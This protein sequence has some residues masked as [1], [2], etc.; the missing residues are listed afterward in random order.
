MESKGEIVIYQALD[1]QSTI[2][3]KLENES[4]WLNLL[5]IST[6]FEK[7]KSV[8]SRHLKNIYREG[9]LD[10]RATVAKNATVQKEGG[11]EVTREIEYFNLDAILSVGYRVNSIRGTQFRIWANKVLKDYLI[12][13]YAVNER[14][15]QEQ[16]RQLEELKQT[17]IGRAHV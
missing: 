16:S 12:K 4:V 7:D 15:L 3:V 9:E 2:V 10:R 14:R 5:Q 17:E 6:L 11:R 1:G 13:G 8:I